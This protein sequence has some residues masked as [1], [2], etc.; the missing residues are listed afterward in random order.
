MG[1]AIDIVRCRCTLSFEDFLEGQLMSDAVEFPYPIP[2][3]GTEPY[4]E[5]CNREQLVMQRCNRCSKFRWHP[6]PLCTH[7]SADGFS[8][9]PL[10]GRGKITTWTQQSQTCC[11]L[12]TTEN[13]IES[14]EKNRFAGTRFTCEHSETGLKDK[15][16][17]VDQSD[18]PQLKTGEHSQL[19]WSCRP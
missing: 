5:A 6:S 19:L 3:Y 16:E 1:C 10:S 14:I 15:L 4:W 13:G 2:E 7:C 17:A 8:W 12:S 11:A 18:V 9:E